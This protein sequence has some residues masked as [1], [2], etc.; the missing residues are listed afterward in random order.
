MFSQQMDEYEI[1]L[2]CLSRFSIW[3]FRN[4]D[5]GPRPAGPGGLDLAK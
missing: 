1:G 2:M 5:Q 4:T 3:K